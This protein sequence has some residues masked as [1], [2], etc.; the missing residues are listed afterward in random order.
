MAILCTID[1]VEDRGQ[2]GASFPWLRIGVL[3]TFKDDDRSGRDPGN[4][5]LQVAVVDGRADDIDIAM[6][7]PCESESQACLSN[8]HI[9]AVPGA[10]S[11]PLLPLLRVPVPGTRDGELAA[12]NNVRC[13]VGVGVGRVLCRGDQHWIEEVTKSRSRVGFVAWRGGANGLWARRTR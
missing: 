8:I 6:E 10:I 7:M 3:D 11:R 2:R 4:Q 9:D 12:Q 13:E 5:G 1:G